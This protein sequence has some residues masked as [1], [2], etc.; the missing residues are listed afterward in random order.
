LREDDETLMVRFPKQSREELIETNPDYAFH[1]TSRLRKRE[2]SSAGLG[3]IERSL[4][5]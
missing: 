2:T 5:S 1:M 4:P 3:E